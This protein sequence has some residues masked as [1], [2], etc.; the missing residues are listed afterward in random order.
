VVFGHR[1]NVLGLQDRASSGTGPRRSARR[2][3]PFHDPD[4]NM[5]EIYYELPDALDMFA[6]GR[7]DWDVPLVLDR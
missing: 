5:L 6:R 4:G 3:S 1:H 7:Q 2:I